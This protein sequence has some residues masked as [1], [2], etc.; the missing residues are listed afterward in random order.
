[1]FIGNRTR[2]SSFKPN[3]RPGQATH[4]TTGL[5][6][7]HLQL[8]CRQTKARQVWQLTEVGVWSLESGVCRVSVAVARKGKCCACAGDAG[9]RYLG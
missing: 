6:P 1:M 2:E 7:A 3:R 5:Q 9:S 8:F 4:L